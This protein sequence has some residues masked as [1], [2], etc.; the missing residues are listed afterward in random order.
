MRLSPSSSVDKSAAI[1]AE[2]RSVDE[3]TH[4]QIDDSKSAQSDVSWVRPEVLRFEAGAAE[5][6]DV[7]CGCPARLFLIADEQRRYA[8]PAPPRRVTSSRR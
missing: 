1:L 8:G 4:N 2:E 7:Q 6:G 5:F 3:Q